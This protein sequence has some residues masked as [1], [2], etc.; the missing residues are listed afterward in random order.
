[1]KKAVSFSVFFKLILGNSVSWERW[2]KH[3]QAYREKQ[4]TILVT[5]RLD[6]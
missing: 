5:D 6:L 1:M 3:T 4:K 2:G